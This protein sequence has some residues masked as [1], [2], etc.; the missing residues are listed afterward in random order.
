MQFNDSWVYLI[1]FSQSRNREWGRGVKEVV[2]LSRAGRGK[3]YVGDI[4]K[5]AYFPAV[6]GQ[7]LAPACR[8]CFPG[9][10]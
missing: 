3:G 1:F 5:Q 7:Q 6:D 8:T 9:Q 4:F 2:L 10:Q